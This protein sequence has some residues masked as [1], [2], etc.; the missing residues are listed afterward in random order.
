MRVMRPFPVSRVVSHIRTVHSHGLPQRKGVSP[1]HCLSKIKHVKG[2]FYVNPCL[3]VPPV[4]NVPNAV[5]GQIV[6]GLLQQFWHIWQEM[7]ANPR[8][9]SVLKDG[10]SLPFNQRLLLTR[11]PLVHSGYANP[12]KSRSLFRVSARSHRETGS[13]KSGYQ[14]VSGFLQLAFS[15]PQTEQKMEANLRSKPV[16]S[17]FEGQFLQDGN[18][19]DNPVILTDRGMGNLAGL[20]RRVFPHSNQQEVKKVLKVLPEQT[21]FPIHSSPLWFGHSSPQVYKGGQRSETDGAGQGYPDPP[22]PR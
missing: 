7:G 16:K 12:T 2:V 18:S 9:V 8:V 5:A 20:Q 1:G 22:V 11:V 21:D 3:S 4:P 15:C 10:Y 17:V 14:I 13:G 6:R 19:G